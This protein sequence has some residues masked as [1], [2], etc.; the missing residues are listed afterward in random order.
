MPTH[1]LF[2]FT[3]VKN[4]NVLFFMVEKME[5]YSILLLLFSGK[6]SGRY[7]TMIDSWIYARGEI[8]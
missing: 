7:L 1:R 4:I 8:D 6:F 2:F 5:I 3:V